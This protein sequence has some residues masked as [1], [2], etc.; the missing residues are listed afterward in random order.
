MTGVSDLRPGRLARRLW[1]W[2]ALIV[3]LTALPARAAAQGVRGWTSTNVQM[4][5]LRPIAMDT[6]LKSQVTIDAFGKAT[7]EG[8]PVTCTGDSLCVGYRALDRARAV[9][10]T[11]DVSLTAWGLGMQGLSVTTTSGHPIT[12]LSHRGHIANITLNDHFI[13]SLRTHRRSRFAH[14]NT[15]RGSN[16]D[17]HYAGHNENR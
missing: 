15:R 5:G 9:V 16:R 12:L 2:S 7:Y 17:Q 6:L 10:A 1:P 8:Q 13:L 11:Q 3:V 4:V 14:G